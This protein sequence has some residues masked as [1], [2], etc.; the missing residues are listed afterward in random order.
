MAVPWDDERL[1]AAELLS[2]ASEGLRA[3][4]ERRF[5]QECGGLSTHAFAVLLQLARAP[6]QQLRM[7]ELADRVG[8]S[9]S[10]LTRAVERLATAGLVRRTECPSDRRGAYAVLTEAGRRRLAAALPVHL[11]HLDECLTAVL[12]PDE[13]ALLTV[14]L[15]KVRDHVAPTLAPT[16]APAGASSR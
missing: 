15:R 12:E 3:A 1:T 4:L 16:R 8:M 14:A 5:A 6:G 11:E 7:S 2:E 10:G 9:P 13:L